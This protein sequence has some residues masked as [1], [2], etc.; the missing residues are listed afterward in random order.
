MHPHA[1]LAPPAH[2]QHHGLN[3]AGEPCALRHGVTAQILHSPNLKPSPAGTAS[4][5]KQLL[6]EVG[7]STFAVTNAH[8]YGMNGF[9]WRMGWQTET[10]KPGHFI[11]PYPHLRWLLETPPLTLSVK[12]PLVLQLRTVKCYHSWPC[13]WDTC[14]Y[15]HLETDAVLWSTER[16]DLV[17]LLLSLTRNLG[18]QTHAN[19]HSFWTAFNRYSLNY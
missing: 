7:E 11:L 13:R 6:A 5:S 18:A 4:K 15:G 14:P 16:A 9:I 1:F 2:G 17:R 3:S 8:T 19:P 10:W 12:M